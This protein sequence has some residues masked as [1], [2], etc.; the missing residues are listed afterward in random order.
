MPVTGSFRFGTPTRGPARRILVA[1]REV[2]R[3][4]FELVFDGNSW[5]LDGH[6]D[7]MTELGV[8]SVLGAP[9]QSP[10]GLRIIFGALQSNGTRTM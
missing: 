7:L 1:D 6:H 9:S 2:G 5:S 8:T 3:G 10:D 4:I